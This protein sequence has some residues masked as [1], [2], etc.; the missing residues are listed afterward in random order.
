MQANTNFK[1]H[2]NNSEKRMY[3]SSQEIIEKEGYWLNT[4][5]NAVVDSWI[6]K[7]K[8]GR[9]VIANDSAQNLFGLQ[10]IDYRGKTDVELAEYGDLN[11]E[12][13]LNSEVSD[14]AVWQE[15]KPICNEQE[16]L[17]A[18]GSNKIFEIKKIPLFS[19]EGNPQA[20]VVMLRDIT[21]H[22]QTQKLIQEYRHYHLEQ[23]E[24]RAVKLELPERQINNQNIE[25]QKQRKKGIASFRM[26]RLG[27]KFCCTVFNSNPEL[28]LKKGLIKKIVRSLPVI[29]YFFDL[30]KQKYIYLNEEIENILGYPTEDIKIFKQNFIQNI[31]HQ[32]DVPKLGENYRRLAQAVDGEIIQTAYRVRHA[33]G[34]WR[35]L[36]NRERVFSRTA[37]GLPDLIVGMAEDITEQQAALSD[38][39]Q[40]EQ[41]WNEREERLRNL[42][43]SAPFLL[44]TTDSNGLCNFL[45]QG[46]LDFTGRSLEEELGHGWMKNIHS[47]DVQFYKDTYFSAIANRQCFEIVYRLKRYDGE[48]R[49]ILDKGTPWFNKT[50]VFEG[51][52]GSCFDITK[53]KQAQEALGENEERFRQMAENINEVF[54]LANAEL[55]QF[56]YISPAC[57]KIWGINCE[58]LYEN[59]WLWLENIYAEDRENAIAYINKLLIENEDKHYQQEYRIRRSDGSISWICDRAFPIRDRSGQIYR[60]A[61][62]AQDITERKLAEEAIRHQTEKERVVAAIT[63]RIRRTLNL[64]EILNI[65]VSEV[66]QLFG[67]DRILIYRVWPE[68]TGSVV[69]EAVVPGREAILGITFPEEV[70]PRDYHQL[71]CQGRV[72]AISDVQNSTIAPC[73]ADFLRELEVK[74]KL[75]VPLIH[76]EELWGLLIAHQCSGP[77]DWQPFEISLMQQLANQLAI[78]IQQAS[79]FEQLEMANQE[80]HRLACLDGLTQVANRRSF[81]EYMQREWRRLCREKAPLA[82]ILCDIDYFKNYNDTYGHPAGDE[83][84]KKVANAIQKSVKRPA[85]F[86]ARYGGEEFAIV[87]PNT[88]AEGAM[89][90]AEKIRSYVTELEIDHGASLVS[91]YITLSLGVAVTVPTITYSLKQLI[92]L[93]DLGLYEAK[94]QGRNRAV[95]KSS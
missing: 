17:L 64:E 74:A 29:L 51:Y 24:D 52:I 78:A 93:A 25:L 61:G 40:I 12:T 53:Q 15:K 71:Y 60:L 27:Q 62:I 48:Y 6:V 26:R 4:L 9:W 87:L 7:D 31:I 14:L 49:W 30:A 94:S 23:R 73:L 58:K 85:D 77:R 76:G 83:C 90:V 45:N 43:N 54:W 32:E 8:D 55:N 72:R 86:V 11:C 10:G 44:W 3:Q 80:L 39:K 41:E 28:Q 91:K 50:G 19:L 92:Y 22:K 37:E 89:K 36:G 33:N 66:Q 95:L 69:T 68:G 47:E 75:V 1:L 2:N 70:F 18:D 59:P 56:F 20:I 13:F 21:E 84:L 81:D 35:W 16:I 79:L 88:N 34:E 63:Q 67:C 57:E 42:I 38:R 5:L 65:A 82:L 46:W